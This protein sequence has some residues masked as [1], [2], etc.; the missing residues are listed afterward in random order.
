M[1]WG[2]QLRQAWYRSR[3]KK[4]E[5][6]FLF[7]PPP[8][9]EWVS[10]DCETTGLDRQRDEIISIGAVKIRGSQ[11]LTS[12][13]LELVVKPSGIIKSESIRVHQLRHQDVQDGMEPQE[14]I[15]RFLQFAG[16]RPLVGYYLEFDVAMLNRLTRPLLG[17]PLPQ[18]K[19]EVSGL[20]Y[21]WKAPKTQGMQNVDLH[22]ST[23]M[24]EL[25]LPER[26][27]HDA[28]NDALMAAM[29]FIKIRHLSG[30]SI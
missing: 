15:V 22:F 19:I 28:F 2:E 3:L 9:D 10:V 13:R 30:Q 12:E 7:E 29:M 21:D 11:I 16:S 6:G 26:S 20:Y 5:Y 18:P 14:A 24:K 23:I 27:A 17:I 25:E 1:S 8:P 4:P